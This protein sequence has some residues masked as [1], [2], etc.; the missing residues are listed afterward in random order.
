MRAEIEHSII[1]RL[2]TGSGACGAN[3][4]TKVQTSS[5]TPAPIAKDCNR[6]RVVMGVRL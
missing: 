6:H 2:S 5:A 4:H 1:E 3:R